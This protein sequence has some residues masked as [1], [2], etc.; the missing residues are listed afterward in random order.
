MTKV[1]NHLYMCLIFILLTVVIFVVKQDL[2]FIALLIG[3]IVFYITMLKNKSI[4]T[5]SDKTPTSIMKNEPV[6]VD[7]TYKE[8]VNANINVTKSIEGPIEA[9]QDNTFDYKNLNISMT[10]I[11]NSKYDIQ[12][13]N[14]D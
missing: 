5:L 13:N 10:M 14:I 1:I 3:I 8:P 12:N 11:P 2:A 7:N 9:Y 6:S 4:I